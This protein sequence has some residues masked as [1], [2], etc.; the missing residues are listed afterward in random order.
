M[1]GGGW[2]NVGMLFF[3]VFFASFFYSAV[4]TR[5]I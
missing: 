5:Y 4:L 3:N 2:G 1:I